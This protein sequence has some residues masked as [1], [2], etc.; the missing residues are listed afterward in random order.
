MAITG[1]LTFCTGD[2][3]TYSL[4]DLPL[5]TAFEWTI[6]ADWTGSSTTNSINTVAGQAGGS[7]Q[8]KVSFECDTLT[9]TLDLLDVDISAVPTSLL[10]SRGLAL[11]GVDDYVQI[12]AADHLDVSNNFSLEFWAKS[13]SSFSGTKFLVRKAGGY[14]VDIID[15]TKLRFVNWGD[16]ATFNDGFLNDGLWHHYALTANG[17]T[18]RKLYIDGT[19]KETNTAAY[20]LSPSAAPLYIG[21][22]AD[23]LEME[24]DELRIWN[25]TLNESEITDYLYCKLTCIDID[26]LAYFPMEQGIA[27]GDNTS[28]T[29]LTDFSSYK[30]H[31]SFTNLSLT[32]SSSN[33]ITTDKLAVQMISGLTSVCSGSTYE[34]SISAI[35]GASS[36]SWTL[37][38]GWTGSSTSNSIIVTAGASNGNIQ[39]S[40]QLDCDLLQLTLALTQAD[41][42]ALPDLTS[43]SK[44]LAL[45]GVDDYV[46]IPHQEQLKLGDNFSFEFWAKTT[47][48]TGYKY[49][50]RK[51]GAYG[52]DIIGGD[53]IVFVTWGDDAHF[54][55]GMINDGT[56]HHYALTANA[57]GGNYS[58]KL[59]RDGTLLEENI[60]AYTTDQ[61][62]A[63]LYIGFSSNP[64]TMGLD[65]LRIWN[66]TLSAAEILSKFHCSLDCTPPELVAYFPFENATANGDNTGLTGPLDYSAYQNQATFVN[67][68]QTGATSNI[69]SDDKRTGFSNLGLASFC[70]GSSYTYSVTGYPDATNYA[71]TLPNG[72]TG[73]SSSSTITAIAGA[74]N[75]NISVDITLPCGVE[76]LSMAVSPISLAGLPSTIANSKVL[77]LDGID[78]Y[79]EIPNQSH[80]NP[81]VDMTIEFWANSAQI[82]QWSA[83]I[84]KPGD[85]GIDIT[86]EKTMAFVTFGN[87]AHFANTFKDDG[88]WHHYAFTASGGSE[89][90]LYVD[91]MIAGVNNDAYTIV[92][93]TNPLRIGQATTGHQIAFDEIRIWKTTKSEADIQESLFCR[94]DCTDETLILY[95]PF[96][97]LPAGGN[98][99]TSTGTM[100]YSVY[101]N[102]TNFEN[103]ALMGN[104]SNIINN[105]GEQAILEFTGADSICV[106]RTNTYTVPALSGVVSYTWTLPS[107]WTGSSTTNSIEVTP[108]LTDGI[109]QVAVAFSCETITLKKEVNVQACFT[110]LDLAGANNYVAIKD[111][112]SLDLP[113]NFSW[114]F[115]AKSD[116]TFSG[117]KFLMRKVGAY[118]IDIQNGDDLLFVTWGDDILFNDA[119]QNDGQWHHYALTAANGNEKKLYV[120]GTL[121]GTDNSTYTI[122]GTADSLYIG[123]TN[124]PLDFSISELSIWNVTLDAAAVTGHYSCS[125]ITPD[126][127]LT[128][129]YDFSEGSPEGNNT[130]ITQ[131]VDQSN[132][133][134]SGILNN[135]AKTGINSN[136]VYGAPLAVDADT[137]GIGD[138]C[139]TCQGN[140]ASGDSDS[141]GICDDIDNCINTDNTNQADA[142]GDGIGDTC[143]ICTGTDASGDSDND[144]ICDD[145]DNCMNTGNS[146]QEDA[147]GDG[148]GDTCD[149][150]IGTDA[151]GDSDNDGICDDIDNCINTSNPTQADA[152]EDNVGDTC[153]ICNGDDASGDTDG[154][155]ICNDLD[156]NDDDD[157]FT[158]AEE[159]NCGSDPLNASDI[160][161]DTD[162]DGS[163]NNE[164][165]DDD[166]DGIDDEFDIN[167]LNPN[168]CG[169]TDGDGCDDC[170][171]GVDGFGAM[172][173][174]LPNNDGT[175]TDSDGICDSGDN[176][177]NTA[178]TDQ[179]DADSDGIGDVCDTCIGD[180]SSGDTDGDGI[181]DNQDTDKDEDGV[182]N[183]LEISCL[184]NPTDENSLPLDTDSDGT[185]DALDE[186]DDNDG[187]LDATDPDT[188]NPNICGDTDGDGCDDCSIGV[189]GFG[190]LSDQTPA[191]DG[192]D[193]DQDGIC[194]S[195]DNCPGLFNPSQGDDDGDGSGNECDYCTGRN[196]TL[197]DDPDFDG[198]CNDQDTDDDG[199][200]FTDTNELDCGSNPNSNSSTPPDA[201]G[202]G[203]CDALDACAGSDDN[204][205][206]DNDAVPDGCDICQGN[207]ATGD[208]DNDGICDDLDTGDCLTDSIITTNPVDGSTIQ[209]GQTITTT[210]TV[211]IPTNNTAI[212]KAG[213]SITLNPGFHAQGTFT[214]TIEACENA[215]TEEGAAS[216]NVALVIA[217][218][219]NLIIQGALQLRI[220]PNPVKLQSQIYYKLPKS[221]QVYLSIYDLQGREVVKLINGTDQSAG[222][223]EVLFTPEQLPGGIYFVGLRTPDKVKTEKIIVIE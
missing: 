18:E 103:F 37:P 131:L 26:L 36:Y 41:L 48:T 72:W 182:Q 66:R 64:L 110:G 52:V 192:T 22:T 46:V 73:N 89:R 211:L 63:D 137:D 199:D 215:L 177:V 83:I 156:P 202:D 71:W 127:T 178:N 102:T 87:D 109:I 85:Y 160:P 21:Y 75:G 39:V 8:A 195:G 34:Y 107:G 220:I 141:D 143:D 9:F 196:L 217:D 6:P 176:C 134:N 171:I 147:D 70:Q 30:N 155:G 150:C 151:S 20:D 14:G 111:D 129:Y 76:Q 88:L 33:I 213:T 148:I 105:T 42:S 60:N 47:E 1:S 208:S 3:Y 188:T 5:A 223:Q 179:A 123:F 112:N 207:D 61:D 95:L 13:N 53:D 24:M 175:D 118:G 163:C 100:D 122:A 43:N 180:N 117:T 97:D 174:N 197:N 136:Y 91:G 219:R 104:A 54:T 114:M 149:I 124:D 121:V 74:N 130:A 125:T 80:L 57:A 146:N 92:E 164:D 44:V 190:P 29:Q 25:R 119:F 206:A 68:A 35:V 51:S 78:D 186:D 81:G 28:L 67:M 210:G 86:N 113:S 16:D 19:L 55:N 90:K 59:Y 4:P 189:D 166:N 152:D 23:P 7:I 120:D 153:D 168:I 62:P 58:R 214:A 139:D 162:G 106:N 145:I 154:D 209:V 132:N 15:G 31:G 69:I 203:V 40:A 128:L 84:R 191:N 159:I 17:G 2:S 65:E 198:I 135:F 79:L 140:N 222:W 101:N 181:C 205:D 27:G 200:N 187:V 32:G 218:M 94:P 170:A 138:S 161:M 183:D 216:R 50:L 185:C 212:F 56:W 82:G 12:P 77:D 99:T 10:A 126:A 184:S 144:G 98:N 96:E 172:A 173:D 45:D 204:L 165:E 133:S 157:A 93:S 193:S 201:D 108:N 142:D 158:D 115:W 11:D 169:D 38:S 194:D 116:A 49:L 221:S 167:P